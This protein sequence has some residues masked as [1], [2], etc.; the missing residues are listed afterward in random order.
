MTWIRKGSNLTLQET[1][2]HLKVM[3]PPEQSGCLCLQ[4]KVAVFVLVC[5]IKIHEI[6]HV[7]LTKS[8]QCTTENIYSA[9]IFPKINLTSSHSSHIILDS[10]CI[11]FP[12]DR[13]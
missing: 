10:Q 9:F 7:H 4:R 3:A 12:L 13:E 5:F 2:Q 8:L 11:F 1:G 6:T